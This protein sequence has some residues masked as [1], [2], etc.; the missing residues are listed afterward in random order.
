M[1]ESVYWLAANP[2]DTQPNDWRPDLIKYAWVCQANGRHAPDDV[3][4]LDQYV[5]DFRMVTNNR[6]CQL[7][8]GHWERGNMRD[9]AKRTQLD[10]ASAEWRSH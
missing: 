4:G 10:T 9:P 3:E 6:Q 1:H 2:H 7:V 5:A 8:R